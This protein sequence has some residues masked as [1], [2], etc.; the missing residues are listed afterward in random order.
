MPVMIIHTYLRGRKFP[1]YPHWSDSFTDVWERAFS[2][3]IS[4]NGGGWESLE[5]MQWGLT[6]RN[7]E[8]CECLLIPDGIRIT[9]NPGYGNGEHHQNILY[10]ED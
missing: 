1:N 7:H 4:K 9:P 6:E 2:P 10:L 3:T 8:H 5:A